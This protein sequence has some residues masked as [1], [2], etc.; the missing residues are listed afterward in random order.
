MALQIGDKEICQAFIIRTSD[1]ASKTKVPQCCFVVSSKILYNTE[2]SSKAF[3]NYLLRKFHINQ[4]VELSPVNNKIRG[5]NHIFDDARQPA[6]V[7]TFKY[8]PQNLPTYNNV[9]KHI[10]VKPNLFFLYYKTIVIEKHDVKNIKQEYF[11][12]YFGGFDWLW[13]V[14]VHGSALDIHFIKR[15][16][17]DFKT[18]REL[19]FSYEQKGGLKMK[20]GDK[21]IDTQKILNYDY[22]D[23][24]KE[25]RPFTTL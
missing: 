18:V 9:I 19:L 25:F 4:V 8:E 7:I 22:L 11:I 24:E 1:F 16:K 13:K 10:T 3:R 21:K 2:S 14:L 20:D 6:A 12:E 5:G 15:L 23:A 17:E